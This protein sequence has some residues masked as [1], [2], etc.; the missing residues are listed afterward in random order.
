MEEPVFC[1]VPVH[2][3]RSNN[4]SSFSGVLSSNSYRS[5]LLP[6]IFSHV[7]RGPSR[8][9]DYCPHTLLTST[10][11]CCIHSFTPLQLLEIVYFHL[12]SCWRD[13]AQRLRSSVHWRNSHA[14]V[15]QPWQIPTNHRIHVHVSQCTASL[16]NVEWIAMYLYTFTCTY[17]LSMHPC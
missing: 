8:C 1:K 9:L 6:P 15:T 11:H 3:M 4:W 5:S 17:S 14:A 2:H 12:Q 7:T 13:D 10:L 16:W